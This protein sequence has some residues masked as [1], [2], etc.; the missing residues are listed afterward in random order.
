M[1]NLLYKSHEATASF[2]IMTSS[3]HKVIKL[4]LKDSVVIELDNNE[5]VI[6]IVEEIGNGTIMV[7]NRKI[8]RA[9][10]VNVIKVSP[11]KL[12]RELS[13]LDKEIIYQAIK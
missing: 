6:G 3:N 1:D 2:E 10:I 9:E 12:W 13:P 7:G 11:K 4:V 5:T 8:T